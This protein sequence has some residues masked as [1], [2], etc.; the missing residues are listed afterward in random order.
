MYLE[1]LWFK[2]DSIKKSWYGKLFIDIYYEQ[3]EKQK[4]TPSEQFHNLI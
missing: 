1:I 2:Q 3:N 4:I